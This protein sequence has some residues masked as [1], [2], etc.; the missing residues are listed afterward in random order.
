MKGCLTDQ[1]REFLENLAATFY[2]F[3]MNEIVRIQ[4]DFGSFSSLISLIG[5]ESL[6][7]FLVENRLLRRNAW[8][9][10]DIIMEMLIDDYKVKFN[11]FIQ[12]NLLLFLEGK[13]KALRV[14]ILLRLKLFSGNFVPTKPSGMERL[15]QR[16]HIQWQKYYSMNTT[17][18]FNGK[19]PSEQSKIIT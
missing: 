19:I 5:R 16:L 4:D 13:F 9:I 11:Y 8:P 14:V 17:M 12:K 1:E 3:V 10:L 2:K 7:D 15:H 6:P 18:I